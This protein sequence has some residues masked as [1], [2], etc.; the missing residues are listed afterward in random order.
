MKALKDHDPPLPEDDHLLSSYLSSSLN[1]EDFTSDSDIDITN[2]TSSFYDLSSS[3]PSVAAASSAHRRHPTNGQ[4]KSVKSC[5]SPMSDDCES[6]DTILTVPREWMAGTGN[7]TSCSAIG[8][9]SSVLESSSSTD[10]ARSSSMSAAIVSSCAAVSSNIEHAVQLSSSMT[11]VT[12]ASGTAQF[13][14]RLSLFL[15]LFFALYGGLSL[16]VPVAGLG[17]LLRTIVTGNPQHR[18]QQQQQPPQHVLEANPIS[19]SRNASQLA[20]TDATK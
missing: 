16:F 19:R 3:C 4:T 18:P 6:C 11:S 10:R 7:A 20:L 15:I 12:T 1:S 8:V 14:V 2:T 9:T 17:Y 13:L 5:Q